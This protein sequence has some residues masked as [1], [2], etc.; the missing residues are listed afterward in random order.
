MCGIVGI[1]SEKKIELMPLLYFG[2]IGLQHRGQEASGIILSDGKKNLNDLYFRRLASAK[3]SVDHLF[4][5]KDI[6]HK[7]KFISGVGHNRYSTAGSTTNLNNV[8]P[9]LFETKHG[10]VGIAQNGNLPDAFQIRKCLKK[11]GEIFL[12]D[13]DT[14]IIPKLILRSKKSSLVEAIKEVLPMIHGSYSLLF[15]TQDEIIAARDPFGFRPLCLG[16]FDHGYMIA[17]EKSAFKEKFGIKFIREVERGEI[18]VINK[19]GLESTKMKVPKNAAYCIFE[20]IYFARPD[21][22]QFGHHV[23]DFRMMAGKLH[24]QR[25]PLDI[26]A[27]VPIPDSALYFSQ[28]YFA[29]SNIPL[30]LA[31][32]RNHY[33]GRTFITPGEKDINAKLSP[34]ESLIHGKAIGLLDDSI[35][36][37]TTS[38]E[39]VN[40]VRKCNPSSVHFNVGSPPVVGNCPF[41]IDIKSTKELATRKGTVKDICNF[42]GADSLTYLDMDDLRTAAGNADDF[43]YG[44][45]TGKY[46][47]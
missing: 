9:F 24:A 20:L 13:S 41:G 4:A 16:E 26:D 39:I 15:I 12:S 21:S 32:L 8:Q 14:E 2:L 40:I 44:C 46:P 1:Y 23:A 36:R 31:L 29:E 19:N 7:G 30:T 17:S 3:N 33:V 11:Q 5:K 10:L 22:Y 47:S 18:L 34:I 25:Y 37:G 42:I 43:C 35:V 45:F 38:G 6:P 28:G 27:V